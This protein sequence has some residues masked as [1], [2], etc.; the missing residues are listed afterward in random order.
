[1]IVTIDGPSGTGKST[2]ASRVAKNLGFTYFNTGALYRALA[3]Y[4]DREKLD[5]I[6][7]A[8]DIPFAV[9]EGRYFV[10]E[11]DVSEAIFTP[12][13]STLSSTFSAIPEVRE[14]LM[15]FQKAYSKT[16]DVVFEGRDLG[17]VV[18]PEAEVKI[19]L[20]ASAEERAK[21]R[22]NELKGVSFEQVL[23]DLVKRDR[24]DTTRSVAPLKQAED[25]HLIDTT[26]LTID[27]VVEKV[28]ERVKCNP[29]G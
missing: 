17:T 6:Q 12:F 16:E 2:V 10:G 11:T 25:A 9:K 3:W 29:H 14:H 15:R 19:F 13:I 4:I 26:D 1:M 20:T 18:F 21:R 7:A 23:S 28:V 24:A 22:F 27:Q 5:P 8:L